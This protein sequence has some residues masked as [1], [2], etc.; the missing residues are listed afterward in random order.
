[1]ARKPCDAR[2]STQRPACSAWFDCLATVGFAPGGLSTLG[3]AHGPDSHDHGVLAVVMV[4]LG[5]LELAGAEP[6]EERRGGEHVA[7]GGDGDTV[8]AEDVAEEPGRRGRRERPV[9][10]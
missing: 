7:V 6:V 4:E 1:M 3:A 8:S 9:P 5:V 10:A 2:F